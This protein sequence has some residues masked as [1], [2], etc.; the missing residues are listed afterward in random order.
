MHV[1]IHVVKDVNKK[2]T[3][4]IS[5]K[6]NYN[7]SAKSME[8]DMAVE[9]V[10]KNEQ[11]VKSKCRIRTLIGDD[12]SS[13]IAALRRLSPYTIHKWSD[14][15]HVKKTFNSKLYDLKLSANLREYFSKVFS[16]AIKQNQGNDVKVKIALENIIPHAF[17]N[18]E[19]CGCYCRKD[20]DNNHVYTYFK[21]GQCLSDLNLKEKLEKAIKPFINSSSQIAQCGSSQSNESF[22][23]TVCSK[24]PKSVFYG[25]SESHSYRVS[26]AVCQKKFRI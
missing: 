8:A 3:K 19:N 5:V 6:K 17:G 26:F 20:D 15:N 7:G 22:N 12:D 25:S 16:L 11:L 10:L 21:D 18:H 2:M 13:A 23:N 4:T 24:H 9:V 1:A 14:F